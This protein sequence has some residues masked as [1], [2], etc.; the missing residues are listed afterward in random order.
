M[1]TVSAESPESKSGPSMRR[2]LFGWLVIAVAAGFVIF[3]L[4][5][6]LIPNINVTNIE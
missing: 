6:V 5:D 4:W 1:G 2:L 3:L